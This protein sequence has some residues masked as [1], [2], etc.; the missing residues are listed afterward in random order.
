MEEDGHEFPD[1]YES[2]APA[3]LPGGRAVPSE[4][5]ASHHREPPEVVD[6]PVDVFGAEE[7]TIRWPLTDRFD[8]GT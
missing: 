1:E 8:G 6:E 7:A 3:H 5:R 2:P 4:P